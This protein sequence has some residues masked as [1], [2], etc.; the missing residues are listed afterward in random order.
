MARS[1]GSRPASRRTALRKQPP[2]TNRP[3]CDQCD[4]D[5]VHFSNIIFEEQY[6]M[7]RRCEEHRP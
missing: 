1:R 5:A 2:P 7:V 6:V 4:A 3:K